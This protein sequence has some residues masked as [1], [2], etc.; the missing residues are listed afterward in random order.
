MSPYSYCGGDP[1]NYYDPDGNKHSIAVFRGYIIITEQFLLDVNYAKESQEFIAKKAQSISNAIKYWNNRKDRIKI[2]GKEYT[3]V[4]NL[5]YKVEPKE[6]KDVNKYD[7]DLVDKS[8]FDKPST[9]GATDY[10]KRSIRVRED[11]SVIN[12]QTGEISTTGAH[13]VGHALGLKHEDAGIMSKRQD[14]SRSDYVSENN[15]SNLFGGVDAV[16]KDSKIDGF[17]YYILWIIRAK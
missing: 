13:E 14:E 2:N 16:I 5:S 11:Y 12:P 6:Y 15:L 17:W 3:V 9:S 8:F 1:I 4:Y 10:D 7:Y